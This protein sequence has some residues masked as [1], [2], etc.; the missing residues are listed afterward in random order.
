MMITQLQTRKG[1]QNWNHMEKNSMV[2]TQGTVL[3][4]AVIPLHTLLLCFQKVCFCGI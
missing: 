4:F 2:P 1:P 3:G